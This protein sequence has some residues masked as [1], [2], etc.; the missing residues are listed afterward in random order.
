[1]WLGT[2]TGNRF[3]HIFP[4]IF[5]I[6]SLSITVLTLTSN[7]LALRGYLDKSLDPFFVDFRPSTVFVNMGLILETRKEDHYLKMGSYVGYLRGRCG[8]CCRKSG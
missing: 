2:A 1:M 3:S 8:G 6:D 7:V 4:S 5:L